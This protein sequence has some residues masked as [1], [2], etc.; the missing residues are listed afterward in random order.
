MFQPGLTGKTALKY[1]FS[2]AKRSARNE[3]STNYGG[4]FGKCHAAKQTWNLH[5]PRLYPHRIYGRAA[6]EDKHESII[7]QFERCNGPHLY[8]E[9]SPLYH[10][11]R[12]TASLLGFPQLRTI[13]EPSTP[14][15]L[16]TSPVKHMKNL[17]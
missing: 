2:T 5:R 11:T 4:R 3:K 6:A 15:I 14:R 13:L 12:S 10:T 8:I 9:F 17:N 16:V 7:I 1:Y